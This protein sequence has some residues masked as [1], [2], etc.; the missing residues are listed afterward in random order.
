MTGAGRNGHTLS[1]STYGDTI[2]Q[3]LA[4]L[5]MEDGYR[6]AEGKFLYEHKCP[7]VEKLEAEVS[8]PSRVVFSAKGL[9][10]ELQR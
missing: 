4:E 3:W 9:H 5:G 8:G 6:R 2:R 1:E 10:S 7:E